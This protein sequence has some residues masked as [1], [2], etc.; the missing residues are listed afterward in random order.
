VTEAG[1]AIGVLMTGGCMPGCW[2]FG[3]D[4]PTGWANTG[5]FAGAG[6]IWNAGGA[7]VGIPPVAA[8]GI[9]GAWVG[10]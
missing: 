8:G 1:W 3:C 5:L 9:E 7:W 10:V 4:N 6:T 2:R